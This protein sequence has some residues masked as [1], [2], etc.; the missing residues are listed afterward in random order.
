MLFQFEA[1][2][3]DL[4]LKKR[5]ISTSQ[6]QVISF[7]QL[8]SALERHNPTNYKESTITKFKELIRIRNKVCHMKPISRHEMDHVN[9]CLSLLVQKPSI[10]K[11]VLL[12]QSFDLYKR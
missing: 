7:S 10:K 5:V 12:V 6:S 3:K 4:L 1:Y 11:D 2:L 9:T 8:V